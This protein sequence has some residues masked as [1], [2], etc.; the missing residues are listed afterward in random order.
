MT[1]KGNNYRLCPHTVQ[2]GNNT[3]FQFFA[4]NVR[5]ESKIWFVINI[6]KSNKRTTYILNCQD[7]EINDCIIIKRKVF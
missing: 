2:Q 5:L 6:W 1:K 7:K 3:H 4:K